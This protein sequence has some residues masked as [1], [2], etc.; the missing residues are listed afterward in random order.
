MS[1]RLIGK[2]AVLFSALAA[3]ATAQQ[4]PFPFQ[5]LVT[6]QGSGVAVQNGAQLTFNAPVGQTLMAQVRATYSGTMVAIIA[7]PPQ[8]FGSNE[9]SVALSIPQS[10]LPVTLGPADTVTFTITFKPTSATLNNAQLSLRFSEFNGVVASPNTITLVLQGT[11]PS[12]SLSY[13]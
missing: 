12:F 3:I 6:E 10:Q 1:S 9:F 11:A 7:E 4:T 8:I 2:G 5:L 13:I